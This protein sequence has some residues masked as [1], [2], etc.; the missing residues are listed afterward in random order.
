MFRKLLFI[1]QSNA[2]QLQQDQ[3]LSTSNWDNQHNSEDN[4]GGD[5]DDD[6]G[7]FHSDDNMSEEPRMVD[8]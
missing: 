6:A 5:A 1:K 7:T 4:A 3:L 8:C 2:S